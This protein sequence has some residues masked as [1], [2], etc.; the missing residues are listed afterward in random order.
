MDSTRETQPHPST[1][2]N[3]SVFLGLAVTDYALAAIAGIWLA[4]GIALLIAPRLVMTQVRDVIR[5]SPSVLRWEVMSIIGG[6]FLLFA[7]QNVPSQPF[8]FITAAGMVCKGTFLTVGPQAWRDR[9]L[10]WCEA[11]E[12]ID[13]RFWGLGLCALAVFLLHALGWI[14]RA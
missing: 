10:A 7:G 5:Q 12:D 4:D 11:R 8:W 2:H 13:L 14:G 6:L 3:P 9:V 1:P